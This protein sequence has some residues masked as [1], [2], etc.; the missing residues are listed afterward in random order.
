M[1]EKKAPEQVAATQDI[2]RLEAKCAE[3]E[4]TLATEKYEH[5]QSIN[6]RDGLY[7]QL[8]AFKAKVLG[9]R[10]MYAIF[11]A[12]DEDGELEADVVN[13]E[14]FSTAFYDADCPPIRECWVY[15]V[16]VDVVEGEK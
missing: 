1:G 14:K 16:P 4:Q 9:G 3:L 2:L 12:P 15:M 10:K 6:Q 8:E 7:V 13:D 5:L 11:H